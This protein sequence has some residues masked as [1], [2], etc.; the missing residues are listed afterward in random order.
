MFD[1]NIYGEGTHNAWLLPPSPARHSIF[2]EAAYQFNPLIR[3]DLSGIYTPADGSFFAGP[4]FTFALTNTIEL[5]AGGSCFLEES[6]AYTASSAAHCIC[7]L[8]GAISQRTEGGSLE[9]KG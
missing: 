8:S 4:F 6:K 9:K 2:A 7:D 3:G 5:L 1:P